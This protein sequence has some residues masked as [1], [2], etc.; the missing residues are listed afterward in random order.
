MSFIIRTI[1]IAWATTKI[2]LAHFV[3]DV[4]RLPFLRRITA[5]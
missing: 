3:D 4:K 1:G 5:A 2:G